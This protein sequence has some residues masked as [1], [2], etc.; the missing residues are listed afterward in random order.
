[1]WGPAVRAGLISLIVVVALIALAPTFSFI[2]WRAWDSVCRLTPMPGA[3]PNIVLIHV[4]GTSGIFEDLR[5]PDD[6][7][8]AGCAVPRAAYAKLTHRLSQ[9]GAKAI[10]FDLM[11]GRRCVYEDDELASAF[12]QAGNVV[13]AATTKAKPG[14][15]GF[16]DPVPPL[17]EAVW[18]VGSPAAHQPNE[19]VRSIPLIVRDEDAEGAG[20]EYLALSLLAF[21]CFVDAEP[22]DMQVSSDRLLLA[23]GRDLPL[24]SGEEIRLLHLSS[25]DGSGSG[26]AVAAFEVVSG[27]NVEE[28]PDFTSWNT[29]IINWMGPGGTVQPH[30]LSDVL[31]MTDAEGRELF[32]GKAV[33]IGKMDWDV[34]WTSVG[35]VPGPEVQANALHT[36]ISGDFVRPMANWAS[37]VLL[38]ALAAPTVLIVNRL[39]G[40]RSVLG[41]VAL[42]LLTVVLARELLV[43]KG[44]WTHLFYCEMSILLAWGVTIALQS[45]KVTGLLSRFVPA[46]LGQPER[47]DLG[48]IRTLDASILWSDIRSFTGI[49]EQVAPEEMLKLLHVYHSATED[50]ITEHGGTIVKTPGDAI[51]AVFWR[52]LRGVSHATCALRAGMEI[53]DK[54]PSL[55]QMWEDAGID[56]DT[57]VGIN[58]GSVAMGLVGKQHL[59]PTVIG[60]VVNVTQ[61]LETMTKDLGYP[62]IFSESVRTRLDEDVPAVCL[63]EVAVKGRKEP[64]KVYGVVGQERSRS[65]DPEGADRAVTEGPNET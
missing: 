19:T 32:G 65:G 44:V 14:A 28:L 40:S 16:D 45:D 34:H 57:G 2:G 41:V 48:E 35:S 51:L 54:L 3:D 1:M 58:A 30:L 59:E 4:D 60:D 47:D 6:D 18:A 63:D 38:V 29:M 62:L 15:V 23:G 27:S 39:K 12:K 9:W 25:G 20:R 37:I 7:P 31:S 55:S 56:F 36:L 5:H 52:E 53:I 50:I 11:F 33:I 24:L 8:R 26:D 10:V 13:V 22:S 21:Q 17:D 64:I 46:F 49:S 42:M 61:R 43:R